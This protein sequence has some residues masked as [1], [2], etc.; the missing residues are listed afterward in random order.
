[1]GF[2]INP[3]DR[4]KETWLAEN[5]TPS[6]GVPTLGSPVGTL[7]VVLVDNYIFT[8]A[9]V[10]YSPGELQAFNEPEDPRPKRW[11]TVPVEKLLEVCPEL[12]IAKSS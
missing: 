8:A 6:N 12:P 7:P 11:F 3:P 2:Y 1:M 5:G 9:A 10:A 4:S